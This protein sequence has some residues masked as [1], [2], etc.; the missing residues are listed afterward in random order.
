MKYMECL[1]RDSGLTVFVLRMT[2]THSIK[3]K[4]I[5]LFY[6]ECI[7]SLQELYR[8]G[9][10]IPNSRNEIIWCNFKLQFKNSPLFIKH[11]SQQGI[12]FGTVLVKNGTVDST[13]I[14]NKLVHKAGFMF[15]IQTIK[16]SIPFAWLNEIHR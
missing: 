10:S 9:E 4:K 1:D 11:W 6:K 7:L 2:P 16:P 8:T 14:F 5:P 12:A 13:G 15:E 3:Q